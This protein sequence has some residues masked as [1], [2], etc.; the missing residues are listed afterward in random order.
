MKFYAQVTFL[1]ALL[2]S[3]QANSEEALHLG[4]IQSLTGIA[5]EDGITIVHAIELAVSEIN[6]SSPI[7]IKLEVEDDQS[8]SKTAVSAF[9][10]LAN[11][12]VDV[13]IG[14]SWSFTSN[15]LMELAQKHKI[16]LLNASTYPEAL[17][18]SRCGE[19]CFATAESVYQAARPLLQWKPRPKNTV[20]VYTNNS[21]GEIQRKAFGKVCEEG[22]IAELGAFASAGHD[23][24]DW[25]TIIPKIKALNPESILL[26]LNKSDVETFLRRAAEVG[27]KANFF[28]SKNT[29]DA[30]RLS[31]LKNIYQDLCFTYPL[32]QIER[33]KKFVRDF[34]ARYKEEPRIFADTAY[35]TVYIV[36][37]AFTRSKKTS[38]PINQI[39][40]QETFSGIVG[41]YRYN[42]ETN[43]STGKSSLVCVKD[44]NLIVGQ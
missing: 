7:K 42:V 32:E 12:R 4:A 1:L 36:H 19:Y 38:K 18:L 39:L 5:A 15:S 25:R 43:L 20:F 35:D 44:G 28:G 16:P 2:L 31:K 37:Q 8:T 14:A 26:L 3:S 11:S 41:T 13:I 9:Q 34:V 23:E 40:G 22:G 24:N 17:E 10:K 27:L 30:F 21:W 33:S 29:Y 6:V